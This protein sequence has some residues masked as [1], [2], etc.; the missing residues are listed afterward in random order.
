[1]SVDMSLAPRVLPRRAPY[2]L[3]CLP[4]C[5]G[6]FTH[7]GPGH[8]PTVFSPHL[9]GNHLAPCTPT[10]VSVSETTQ[11]PA[12][13]DTFTRRLANVVTHGPLDP[14]SPFLSSHDPGLPL[15]PGSH[16]WW[17]HSLVGPLSPPPALLSPWLC[18]RLHPIP[19]GPF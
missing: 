15:F 6:M 18:C 8:V 5:P 12:A 11:A 14:P 19:W 3:L 13:G 4:G 9:F 16:P 2:H 10:P 1:M 17:P 7:A